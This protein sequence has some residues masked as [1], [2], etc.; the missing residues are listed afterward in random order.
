MPAG[1]GR[2]KPRYGEKGC[3][4]E[5]TSFQTMPK[6]VGNP[7]E[8]IR[9]SEHVPIHRWLFGRVVR[10]AEDEFDF[11]QN[12]FLTRQDLSFVPFSPKHATDAAHPPSVTHCDGSTFLF[13][14]T[15]HSTD[16]F[17]ESAERIPNTA[18][19]KGTQVFGTCGFCPSLRAGR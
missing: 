17:N 10:I 8:Q 1:R 3:G 4:E 11:F 16:V 19:T 15:L 7:T 9:M 13:R 2:G 6:D 18:V 5:A 12:T 14:I